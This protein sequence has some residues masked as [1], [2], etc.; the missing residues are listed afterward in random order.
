RLTTRSSYFIALVLT[1]MF[2]LTWI[3]TKSWKVAGFAAV[4][5]LAPVYFTFS[6]MGYLHVT[7]NPINVLMV[8]MLIPLG[9]AFTIHARAYAQED[10][11][12]LI[13]ILP[14]NAVVPFAFAALT[15]MIGFG[16]TGIS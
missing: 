2:L 8:N 9:A 7:Q 13:G 4:N 12:T 6:L 11:R 5:G 16:S 15:T 14:K 3:L 10:S 1:F